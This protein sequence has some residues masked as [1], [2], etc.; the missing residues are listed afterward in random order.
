MNDSKDILADLPDKSQDIS[1][2]KTTYFSFDTFELIAK[3][4]KES[5]QRNSGKG[6][7]SSNLV[8][9]HF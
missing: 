8:L 4:A 1:Q 9:W 7:S 2:D 3:D 6:I 5:S